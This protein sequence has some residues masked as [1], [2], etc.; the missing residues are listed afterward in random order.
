MNGRRSRNLP[1]I[2]PL[3]PRE[4]DILLCLGEGLSNQAIAQRLTLS[5]NTVKWYARQIYNK[6]GAANRKEAVAQARQWGLLPDPAQAARPQHNLPAQT[7]S[8]VGREGELDDLARLLQ[9]EQ[10]RLINVAGPGGIGKTRL[11]LAAAERALAGGE[12][13]ADGVF[14]VS[15]TPLSQAAQ[16]A[17]AVA[18]AVA[19]P[20]E[21]GGQTGRDD[22]KLLD[23]L[24]RKQLLLVLDNYEH[25]LP[26]T[27]LLRAILAEA[28]GVRL[29]VTS[30]E[31][32]NLR[33]EHLFPL[34]G[35]SYPE[36]GAAA[37]N[38]PS[39]SAF[40]LFAARARQTRPDY[41]LP[42]EDAA[43]LAEICRLV[44]GMPLALELAAGWLDALSVAAIA[45]ELRQNLSLL[46]TDATDRPAR[47]RRIFAAFE[48]AWQR[49]SPAEQAAFAA[50][51]VFRGG[52]TRRAAW[53]VSAPEQNKAGF[54]RILA[55]LAGK[56][57][58]RYH[59]EQDRY[60]VHELL[61]QFGAAKLGQDAAQAAAVQERHSAFY[62]HF[63]AERR[64][65]LRGE[66]Q[67]QARAAVRRESDNVRAAWMRAAAQGRGDL[68]EPALDALGMFY[69]GDGRFQA[70]EAA[71]AAAAAHWRAQRP[72]AV[73]LLGKALVWQ[74]VFACR[75]GRPDAAALLEESLALLEQPAAGGARREQAFAWRVKGIL[76]HGSNPEAAGSLLQKS[77]TAAESLGD[78]WEMGQT[79]TALGETRFTQGRFAQAERLLRQSLQIQR[80]LGD[81]RSMAA[82]LELLNAAAAYQGKFSD[83]AA[84]ARQSV[85]NYRQIGGRLSDANSLGRQGVTLVW[86]GEHEEAR[87][88]LE[89]SLAI[90]QELGSRERIAALRADL[91]IAL[92]HLGRYEEAQI[93]GEKGLRLARSTGSLSAQAYACFALGWNG[94]GVFRQ[95]DAAD[96]LAESAAIFSQIGRQN[97]VW[98][99]QTL[100]GIEMI[101]RERYAEAAECLN[102]LARITLDGRNALPLT[103]AVTGLALLEARRINRANPDAGRI[104][105]V[106]GLTVMAQM[107]PGLKQSLWWR[108]AAWTQLARAVSLL[109]VEGRAAAQPARQQMNLWEAGAQLLDDSI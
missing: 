69:E 82:T 85:R 91:A 56:S 32:L 31:K 68:L 37:V 6:L 64:E 102:R 47:H 44:E 2:Q 60:D 105:R 106:I 108:D 34:A 1:P 39:F 101:W 71:F 107:W 66:T 75:L 45:G 84:Y 46:A 33:A 20:L 77:L 72:P 19:C 36:R 12:M 88:K 28:P 90:Y 30:R 92:L 18:A 27:G 23:Y 40:R 42:P 73:K 70:G 15:L 35:L 21:T 80:Q 9:T 38:A 62:C 8:F 94:V 86:L 52:F 43:P 78:R 41:V 7:T 59:P 49:L 25:L 96:Y 50:L 100:L 57:L 5:L 14:F 3:T 17:A 11:A 53:R 79:L 10:I 104:E 97:E 81:Y 67:R 109:P 58:A 51:S 87:Q 98:W 24:R 22:R 83:A 55:S 16:M 74:S 76:L 95:P 99:P 89:E 93:E 54:W 65:A 103:L 61:R 29:I 4:R 13:F 26:E 48:S 63:L